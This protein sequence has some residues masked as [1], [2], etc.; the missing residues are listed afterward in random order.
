[1][2]SFARMVRLEIG[3]KLGKLIMTQPAQRMDTRQRYQDRSNR[4]ERHQFWSTQFRNGKQLV[5]SLQKEFRMTLRN[6]FSHALWH[7]RSSLHQF[8]TENNF[9]RV[10]VSEYS[11]TIRSSPLENLKSSNQLRKQGN[12]LKT[13]QFDQT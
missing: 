8:F 11:E 6:L 9:S 7:L 12:T 13:D 4:P 3:L 1:M 5:T 10:R 2:Y